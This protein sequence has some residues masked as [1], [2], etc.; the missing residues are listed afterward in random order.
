ML[1]WTDPHFIENIGSESVPRTIHDPWTTTLIEAL[2]EV[3]NLK[4]T[5]PTP[6]QPQLPA[7]PVVTPAK[8]GPKILIIDDTDMLL[9]FVEDSLALADP[10]LQVATALTGLN[11]VKEAARIIPDL[12]LA[13]YVLPDIKGDEVCRRIGRNESTALCRSS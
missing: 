1:A 5:R 2:R 9:I 10:T 11:G 13:D 3:K 4:R 12:V 7:K 6:A 8:A